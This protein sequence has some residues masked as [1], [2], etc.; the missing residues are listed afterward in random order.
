MVAL[1]RL[2][3]MAVD[4]QSGRQFRVDQSRPHRAEVGQNRTLDFVGWIADN[5][6][7]SKPKERTE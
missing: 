4:E 6:G 1:R 5:V 3:R 7:K 2:F